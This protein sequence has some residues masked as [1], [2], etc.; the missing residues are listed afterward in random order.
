MPAGA[1]AFSKC[2]QPLAEAPRRPASCSRQR[3]RPAAACERLASRVLLRFAAARPRNASAPA[4]VGV[5][6][7]H[8]RRCAAATEQSPAEEP[9]GA[10]SPS[11]VLCAVL[12]AL[13]VED[14]EALYPLLALRVS[15]GSE[16]RLGPFGAFAWA[17][18]VPARRVLPSHAG[19]QI[20]SAVEAVP[21]ERFVARL[22]AT[23]SSGEEA[24]FQV[25]PDDGQPIWNP[26]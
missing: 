20:L 12:A 8:S 10:R 4:A 2:R 17:L 22:Q 18:D 3:C 25:V 5:V 24:V 16:G 14:E 11:A 7:R 13:Q 19:V 6:C 9:S 1:T 15:R 23:A 21:G 26:T